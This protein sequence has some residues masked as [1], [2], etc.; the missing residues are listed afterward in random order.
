MALRDVLGRLAAGAPVP[1]F[2]VADGGA[3]EA[4]QDLRLR[5]ELRVVDTPTAAA[6]LIIAG[7]IPEGLAVPLARVHDA[8]PHPRATLLWTVG[9]GA[10]VDVSW[11]TEAVSVHGDVV[12]TAIA[13]YGDLVAGTRSSEPPVLPDVDPAPWRGVGPYGQGGTGMTGG[14]PY[15]RPLAEVANDRDGLRLDVLPLAVG[16]FFPRFPPGLVVDVTLAGDVVVEASVGGPSIAAGDASPRPVLRPFLRALDEPVPI[17]EL[18]LARAREHLRWLCDALIAHG[19]EALGVRALRLAATVGPGDSRAVVRL[20]RLVRATQVLRWST[21]R[22]GVL[23]ADD[24]TGLG[25]GPAARAAGLA[26]DVRLEDPAYR[27]L[28]FT[29]VL[30]AGGDAAARWVV[31]LREAAQSLDLAGRAGRRTT[32]LSGRVESPRG[33]LERSS[34]PST[35]LLDLLPRAL[36]GAEWGDAV[37]TIVSLDL[38]LAEAAH[39][40][41]PTAATGLAA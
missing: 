25:A 6:L 22:V 3:R 20:A 18:E 24:L 10:P 29:P 9:D 37:A 34:A 41:V 27:D 8:L 21:R 13:T 36:R 4:A 12:P 39:G 33:R 19:L 38:D 11:A 16:P 35:R 32:G 31:R 30:E 14:T 2:A 26:E 1:V 7:S 15:G 23:A 5:D 17:A 40:N 28:G